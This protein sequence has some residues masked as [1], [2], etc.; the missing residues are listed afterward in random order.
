MH[1]G[2]RPGIQV[3]SDIE[4]GQRS[5]PVACN[6]EKLKQEDAIFRI[7]WVPPDLVLQFSERSL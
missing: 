6:A 4:L 5:F 3:A 7:R 2:E 1:H